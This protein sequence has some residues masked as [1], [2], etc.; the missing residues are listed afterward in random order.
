M[1]YRY[2]LIPL[3]KLNLPCLSLVPKLT[4]LPLPTGQTKQS[5]SN[6]GMPLSCDEYPFA[7]TVEGGSGA[8]VGCI[9]AWQNGLQGWYLS[10]FFRD[11][12]MQVNDQFVMEIT[13]IDCDTVKDTDIPGCNKFGKRDSG[14]ITAGAESLLFQSNTSSQN[15]LVIPFGDLTPGQY[16]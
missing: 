11:Y 16:V 15:A 7:S 5:G 8:H 9:V 10:N 13:G 14:N 1:L 3:L 4:S 12:N 2:L 6:A